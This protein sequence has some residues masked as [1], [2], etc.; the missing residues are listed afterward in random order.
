MYMKTS[1]V[2]MWQILQYF[3]P[4][5]VSGYVYGIYIRTFFVC[6]Y[7]VSPCNYE[8]LIG[9]QRVPGPRAGG[10][11]LYDEVSDEGGRTKV[12]GG[13]LI[14]AP[15]NNNNKEGEGEGGRGRELE[16]KLL[17]VMREKERLTKTNAAL[18]KN[19]T[20]LQKQV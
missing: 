11:L 20:E 9:P 6:M 1:W 19:V 4:V 16:K 14:V 15:S 18:Q 17:K 10:E 12:M 2:K 3:F 8:R 5:K 7:W 13:G